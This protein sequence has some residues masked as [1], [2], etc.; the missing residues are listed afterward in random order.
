MG[1]NVMNQIVRNPLRRSS[2]IIG[3]VVLAKNYQPTQ[4]PFKHIT[5]AIFERTPKHEKELARV[6]VSREGKF[7]ASIDI[8]P[9]CAVQAIALDQKSGKTLAYS[10]PVIPTGTKIELV[11]SLPKPQHSS[12]LIRRLTNDFAG[13][14]KNFPTDEESRILWYAQSDEPRGQVV[15]YF[16]TLTLCRDI[17]RLCETRILDTYKEYK[18]V[19]GDCG[20]LA[21]RIIKALGIFQRHPRLG[22]IIFGLLRNGDDRQDAIGLL[23]ISRNAFAKYLNNSTANGD[24]GS[25]SQSEFAEII[26]ALT[27]LRDGIHLSTQKDADSAGTTVLL[28]D[29]PLAEASLL[30]DH[31]LQGFSIE[32]E[33]IQSRLKDKD[34]KRLEFANELMSAVDQYGPLAG[35]FLATQSENS[36]VIIKPGHGRRI[37][38]DK[39]RSDIL[40]YTEDDWQHLIDRVGSP[41]MQSHGDGQTG[42]D[43]DL[44]N[45]GFASS[46]TGHFTARN[47]RDTL[48]QRL[49]KAPT[50]RFSSAAQVLTANP[51]FDPKSQA[52]DVYFSRES[53]I[54]EEQREN[55][56]TVARLSKLVPDSTEQM[57]YASL[58]A[59]R[60]FTSANAIL[61]TGKI[62]FYENMRDKI[63]Q[64]VLEQTYCRSR[65]MGDIT[66]EVMV[67]LQRAGITDG[68][69]FHAFVEGGMPSQEAEDVALPTLAEMFGSLDACACIECQSVHSPAAYLQNLLHWMRSDIQ[70]AYPELLSRRRDIPKLKLSCNNTHRVLPYIDLTN[71]ALCWILGG[72]PE[73]PIETTWDEDALRL[74][75]EYRYTA[76]EDQLKTEFFPRA[77][78]FNRS[79][80]EGE[81]ALRCAGSSVAE[82]MSFLWAHTDRYDWNIDQFIAYWGA[83]LGLP[84]DRTRELFAPTPASSIVFSKYTGV[85]SDPERFVG[86]IM[87]AMDLDYESLRQVLDLDFVRL[88][89][90]GND[91]FTI[92]GVEFLDDS[93]SY[94]NAVFTP[95]AGPAFGPDIIWRAVRLNWLS[96]ASG[97]DEQTLSNWIYRYAHFHNQVI[98]AQ[99]YLD[100]EIDLN[101]LRF[102][103][104]AIE[105]QQLTNVSIEET[106]QYLERFAEPNPPD[107]YDAFA[108]TYTKR[109]ASDVKIAA[110][111]VGSADLLNSDGMFVFLQKA[112]PLFS[113][114]NDLNLL[115][116]IVM[117]TGA[118]SRLDKLNTS[119]QKL[120]DV[121]SQEIS[122]QH[123][124]LATIQDVEQVV[125]SVTAALFEVPQSLVQSIYNVRT[126]QWMNQFNVSDLADLP[127][128]LVDVPDLSDYAIDLWREGHHTWLHD[129]LLASNADQ[130]LT[131]LAVSLFEPNYPQ[132]VPDYL[133]L[134]SDFPIRLSHYKALNA[135]HELTPLQASDILNGGNVS[136]I[137]G[138]LGLSKVAENLNVSIQHLTDIFADPTMPDWELP[139]SNSISHNIAAELFSSVA[140]RSKN[141]RSKSDTVQDEADQIRQKFRDA[142]LAK[143]LKQFN[144]YDDYDDVYKDLLL[145]PGMQPCMLTSRLKLAISSVQLLLHRAMLNLEYNITVDQGDR[146]EWAWRSAYRF[147]EANIKV[148]LYPECWIDPFLRTNNTPLLEQSI[149]LLSQDEAT[150]EACEAIVYDYLS[151]LDKIARLDIRAFLND[152]DILHVFGRT[153]VAPY[154]Y[155]YRRREHGQWTPWENIGIDI[156]GVH[157]IP[158][159]FFRRLWLF[160]PIFIEKETRPDNNGD[161]TYPYK[162]I[163]LAYSTFEHGS[164]RGKKILGS[165]VEAGPRA[166]PETALN[167][168]KKTNN[169]LGRSV[170]L[171]PEDFLF[172]AETSSDGSTLRINVRRRLN[173]EWDEWSYAYSPA[174][175]E[176]S[177]IISGCNS[178]GDLVPAGDGES[179]TAWK[180]DIVYRPYMTL[181]HGQN[182]IRGLDDNKH[183]TDNEADISAALYARI[184][185]QHQHGSTPLLLT[186]P[187]PYVLTYPQKRH[188]YWTEPFFMMDSYHTHFF[189][190]EYACQYLPTYGTYSPILGNINFYRK[191]L[192]EKYTVTLHEH[193]HACL[194]IANFNQYG[195]DGTYA[196]SNDPDRLR[197]QRLTDNTY[198]VQNY[199]PTPYQKIKGPFPKLEFDF[200]IGSAYGDYNWELFFHLPCLFARQMKS[201]SRYEEAIRW[202]SMVFDP[203][204][205]ENLGIRRVWRLKPFMNADSQS[206]IASLIKLLS[207]G[208]TDPAQDSLQTSFEKQIKAWRDTPF[209]PHRIA[210]HRLSAYMMWMAFEYIDVLCDWGDQ[211]FKQDSIESINE[212]TNLYMLASEILGKRSDIVDK[213]IEENSFSYEELLHQ[214][215]TDD[216]SQLEGVVA[217]LSPDNGCK[218]EGCNASVLGVL[219]TSNYFC[220]PP[221]PKLNDYWDKIEDR[222][223]KIRHCRNFDGDQRALTLFQPPISPAMLVKARAAGLSIEEALSNLSEPELCYRFQVLLQKAQDFTAEVKAFGGQL[224]SSMEKQDSAVLEELRQTHELNLQRL[225]INLKKMSIEEA[226]EGLAALKHSLTNAENTLTHY[227]DLKEN[228]NLDLEDKSL[229]QGKTS[230]GLMYTEQALMLVSGLT[231]LIPDP[232]VGMMN[233][234]KLPGGEKFSKQM[235]AGAQGVGIAGSVYRS[236]SA[237]SATR[238]GYRRREQDWDLQ[239]AQN[240]ERVFELNRQI[241]AA[242]IRLQTA[243]K[244]LE[245]FQLQIE[246]SQQVYGYVRSRFTGE[247]LYNWMIGELKTL[248]RQAYELA[249][250]MARQAQRA[251]TRELRFSSGEVAIISPNH[252]DGG[253]A[254]LLAG[255]KL[256]FELKQLDDAYIREKSN[257][258]CFELSRQVSLRRLDPYQLFMLKANSD[259]HI[260]VSLPKWLFQS[261]HGDK[262]LSDMRIKSVALSILCTTGPT[263]R[264][265]LRLTLIKH[266]LFGSEVTAKGA[267]QNVI[268]T[269]RAQNDLGRFEPNLNGEMY[270]PFENVGVES[271]WTLQLPKNLEFDPATI[272]D[273]NFDI[274]YTGLENKDQNTI[275]DAAPDS[276]AFAVS[277]RHDF[278]DNWVELTKHNASPPIPFLNVLSLLPDASSPEIER[279]KPYIYS[280]DLTFKYA[281]D[282]FVLGTDAGG[283]MVV[284]KSSMMALTKYLILLRSLQ[285]LRP[286][287]QMDNLRVISCFCYRIRKN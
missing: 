151:G 55:L 273:I 58:M 272:T 271:T 81:A 3:T 193:P 220:V 241:L 62:E 68:N 100:F 28:A 107:M 261:V 227:T 135:K 97:Y 109:T 18:D 29:P 158:V 169:R 79:A 262:S 230:D 113:F 22:E 254:G 221:N 15:R 19:G 237:R 208:T 209:E 160:W 44:V 245:Q 225:T 1:T 248:H 165:I 42:A 133:N 124:Q 222:L 60:G 106:L 215:Y 214:P 192:A 72:T 85:N 270:L 172:I 171:D 2:E 25:F 194:L 195:V 149:S 32:D 21:G 56:R 155:F 200:T 119:V 264:V 45:K 104:G 157:V 253:R 178:E 118:E 144:G 287:T 112:Q 125:F 132:S 94:D 154:E 39:A 80:A 129:M 211:L 43:G 233:M 137:A 205:R 218:P 98:T 83:V 54:S 257:Q 6:A 217:T 105:L 256:S 48:L 66:G 250:N 159:I 49:D 243:E 203:T 286:V 204:S 187:D 236:M 67:Q 207:G 183:T 95:S 268:I 278:Y 27:S 147:W 73:L 139:A 130:D 141:S 263:T 197:R 163:R 59:D 84:E 247:K 103:S 219:S 61:R 63:P 99:N 127:A 269:S 226:K 115:R 190:R 228:K 108:D 199:N 175:F 259:Q 212:A 128:T 167:I 82:V 131:D 150:E 24:I 13:M 71:E 284:L 213:S 224:L 65:T 30:F 239:I 186:A 255:D 76:A 210:E 196:I 242:E 198:F 114:V 266:I 69:Q 181:I 283:K 156:E 180:S 35:A 23:G 102:L 33:S 101:F 246:Q 182:M 9:R 153:W 117:S 10:T 232:Y 110:Q 146:E 285:F 238:A 276:G 122:S 96:Q 78:P 202:L 174:E 57:F 123:G 41:D 142:L 92:D 91:A 201:E 164:W 267:S 280:G 161:P 5:V 37:D 252:W 275:T 126:D 51:D 148:L 88:D 265:D 20:R 223:F 16:R 166:G 53:G 177:Y 176:D 179:L 188:A 282:Y 145:D 86:A 279:V 34:Y 258:H 260:E 136:E 89:K 38:P 31:L 140:D 17:D 189:E 206:N 46:I 77:L 87:K 47:P 240:N 52:V 274:R 281:D 7:S 244:D 170:G 173:A 191:I 90:H 74:Q 12:P 93:C 251:M 75:P 116:P 162:E 235:A 4:N 64:D 111:W 168:E 277:L 70:G 234:A 138:A 152:G 229:K 36:D 134:P 249:A 11:I 40:K 216:W 231:G 26:D 121:I 50:E 8:G 120:F 184:N 14:E 185:D 143:V